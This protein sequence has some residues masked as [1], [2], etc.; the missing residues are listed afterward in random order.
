MNKLKTTKIIAI[1]LFLVLG[2]I[3]VL[4]FINLFVEYQLFV[5]IILSFLSIFFLVL[6]SVYLKNMW[7]IL[8]RESKEFSDMKDQ[9]SKALDVVEKQVVENEHKKSALEKI[10]DNARNGK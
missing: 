5:K 8:E 7:F 1:L 3:L 2:I 10:L 9:F 4:L 6:F